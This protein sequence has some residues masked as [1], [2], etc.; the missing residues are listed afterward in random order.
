MFRNIGIEFIRMPLKK[1][2]WWHWGGCGNKYLNDPEKELVELRYLNMLRCAISV[3]LFTFIC[4]IIRYGTSVY[5]DWGI[6]VSINKRKWDL[7]ER[8]RDRLIKH[9]KNWIY[10]ISKFYVY[11]CIVSIGNWLLTAVWASLLSH[12]C[13]IRRRWVDFFYDNQ[14]QAPIINLYLCGKYQISFI[15]SEVWTLLE[16]LPWMKPRQNVVFQLI[17]IP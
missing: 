6:E 14:H 3:I 11:P 13:V 15:V 4:H 17:K 9:G 10:G 5:G 8:T 16:Q 12:G 7:I 1:H 2:I